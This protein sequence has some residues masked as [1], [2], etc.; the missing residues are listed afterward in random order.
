MNKIT[1]KKVGYTLNEREIRFKGRLPINVEIERGKDYI[2][3]VVGQRVERID[4]ENED[5]TYDYRYVVG[6][7]NVEIIEE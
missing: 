1:Q 5:G 6:I 2:F 4:K 3:R 7:S